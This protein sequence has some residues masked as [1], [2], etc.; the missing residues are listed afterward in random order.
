MNPTRTLLSR[1]VD[2][3]LWWPRTLPA[4]ARMACQTGAVSLLGL[5]VLP[6]L[7]V[8]G[9][10]E[11]TRIHGLSGVTV[12]AAECTAAPSSRL[13]LAS[14]GRFQANETGKTDGTGKATGPADDASRLA[15]AKQAYEAGQDAEAL[16]IWLQLQRTS[17]NFAITQDVDYWLVMSGL[18][19][20][21]FALVW[22]ASQRW[23]AAQPEAVRRADRPAEG[24]TGS[25]NWAS[26]REMLG[27]VALARIEAAY[28]QALGAA[29]LAAQV[30]WLT[31]AETTAQEVQSWQLEPRF[32]E[33]VSYHR[34]LIAL[35]QEL[36][37]RDADQPARLQALQQQLRAAAAAASSTELRDKQNYYAAVSAE[38]LGDLTSATA[39][40]TQL[41]NET[42]VDTEI[43]HASLFALAEASINRWLATA[44]PTPDSALTAEERRNH[45]LAA[46]DLYLRLQQ[47]APSYRA[48]KVAFNLGT[49]Y[50]WL[51]DHAAAVAQFER[52]AWPATTAD[53]NANLNAIAD[54]DTAGNADAEAWALA[55]SAQFN[56]ARSLFSL[57]QWEAAVRVLDQVL[58]RLALADASSGGRAVLLR[59]QLAEKLGQW[60]QLLALAQDGAAWLQQVPQQQ[61]EVDY[62][63]AL[64]RFQS[65]D[66]E[67]R[68]AGA[69]A[70]QAL[71]SAPQHPFADLARLQLLPW[72][73]EA[74]QV[75][76]SGQWRQDLSSSMTAEYRERLEQAAA[77]ATELLESRDMQIDTFPTNPALWQ[78]EQ[79][80]VAARRQQVRQW[81]AN[82]WF[83]LGRDAEAERAYADL[84]RDFPQDESVA[85]WTIK[86]AVAIARADDPTAALPLLAESTV[87]GWSVADQADAWWVVG[88]LHQQLQ[89]ELA[90]ARAWEAAWERYAPGTDK[91][92]ALQAAVAAYQRA[93]QYQ[94]MLRLI[95][96]A[97]P[98]ATGP[99]AVALLLQ[100]GV[101]QYFLR[102]HAA[103]EA[104]FQQ[105]ETRA[106]QLAPSSPA[107][108]QQRDEWVADARV[109]RGLALQ[110]LGRTEDAKT[111]WESF[112]RATPN[113]AHNETVVQWLR[114]L[115]PNWTAPSLAGTDPAG[116]SDAITSDAARDRAAVRETSGSE[117]LSLAELR[118]RAEEAF[119]AKRWAE[120]SQAW[121]RLA[122]Q[123]PR[124]A[125]H[126]RILYLWAW[127][128][129]EQ[130]QGAA[131]VAAWE[132]LLSEH[133]SSSWVGRSQFHLGEA[134][135][136]ANDYARAKER[137]QSARTAAAEASLQRSALYM[138]AWSE[139]KQG[140][141]SQARRLFQTLLEAAGTTDREQPLVLEAQALLAQCDFQAGDMA[142]AVTAYEAASSAV[143]KLRS[144]KPELAFQ[145][146]LNAGRA[147]IETSQPGTAILWL[148]RGQALI[149][150]GS[151]PAEVD[152]RTRAEVPF[153]LGVALRLNNQADAA[154][155][156]LSQVS[157]RADTVG[158]RA[159][160]E[161]AQI[162]RAQGDE[163]AARRHYQAIANGAYGDQLPPAAVELK[164]QALLEVGLS[165]VRAANQQTDAAVRAEHLRQAKTWLTRAQL[166]SDSV[167]VSQQAER[168][169][170][171][172]G[173]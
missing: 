40:W 103:A 22:D 116:S 14:A 123:S 171:Q 60:P 70:L 149:D 7:A 94:E 106:S 114:G 39:I 79:I 139:L 82:A 129:R 115:D 146:C 128:L 130:Q 163:T 78:P 69:T 86:R 59:M 150:S 62:L 83:K 169:L 20:G 113:H 58:P 37:R 101:A 120:S 1:L 119:A 51:E 152:E 89:D 28:Q 55:W 52:I 122:T 53:A 92:M 12:A 80:Q 168:Q 65:T 13:E 75:E 21:E 121:E 19:A 131:A 73:L 151:L 148:N 16:A 170:A 68:S 127:A 102:D 124:P 8:V 66:S 160:F 133:I 17:P 158:L 107:E 97:A 30:Q 81:Q 91:P 41:A 136:Q 6:D 134:A 47:E 23:I 138:E 50:R 77:T 56:L 87:A 118:V 157:G 85:E 48:H 110:Q 155:Q 29:D 72:Q 143:D 31:R 132:Q 172:L 145:S 57:Q 159:L 108:Q 104:S 140:Q 54:T 95:D 38:L 76:T 156:A 96:R 98:A 100:R 18:R 135:Y 36:R 144:L 34:N 173:T 43:R 142:A 33:V 125:D 90:A 2:W 32:A 99:E 161:L 112:L 167:T 45:L 126:D 49:C 137:F 15:A 46:R 26:R 111:V 11:L 67:Q 10:P 74:G 93:E 64:S 141:P 165:F 5:G 166:Q 63:T 44:A 164:A 154:Q 84:L 35:Q 61:A 9:L 3:R 109:N 105:V 4:T 42:Q 117:N 27:Q 71:A 162:A 88:Q 24:A 25:L 147:A 153:L